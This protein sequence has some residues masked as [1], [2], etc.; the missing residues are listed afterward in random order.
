MDTQESWILGNYLGMLGFVLTALER[1]DE[2]QA[3]LVEGHGI[4]VARHGDKD[5]YT[6]E[7]VG[8]LADLYAAWH[9][10][11]PG[12]GYDAKAAEWR[13][14]LPPNDEAKEPAP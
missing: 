2:A 14:K 8:Y 9:T 1:Y 5:Y 10:A 3:A 13:A 11:E 12:K 4:L 6:T 7:V